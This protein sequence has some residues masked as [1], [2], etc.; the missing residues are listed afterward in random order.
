MLRRAIRL[1]EAVGIWLLLP[2]LA[3]L[4]AGDVGLR[5]ALN[6]PLQWGNDVKKLLLLG[7]MTFGLA[8]TSLSNQHI[9]VVLFDEHLP[10]GLR[11]WLGRLRHLLA[12]VVAVVGAWALADLAVDMHRYGDRAEMVAIPLAPVAALA[13]LAAAL[14]ALAEFARVLSPDDEGG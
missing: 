7:V 6:L 14:S 3:L 5:Y 8:G 12:G 13:M 2:A 1:T 10:A 9:R 11:R 4:V